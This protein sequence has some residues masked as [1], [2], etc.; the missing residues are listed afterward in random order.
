MSSITAEASKRSPSMQRQ[1]LKQWRDIAFSALLTAF[2]LWM[3]YVYLTPLYQSILQSLSQPSREAN[4]PSYPSEA[5]TF[6][7]DAQK[8]N[9]YRVPVDGQVRELALL[10]PGRARSVFIDPAD[11]TRKIEWEGSYRSLDRLWL[12]APRWSNYPEAWRRINFGRALLNTVALALISTIGVILSGI[13]VA[14]G[15]ARFR[16]PGKPV[17]M[18]VL[19]MT[20]MLPREVLFVSTYLMFYKLGWIGTW[21]PMIVPPFFGSATSIFLLRQF[22]L[23]IPRDLDEAAMIDG[24]NP[25]QILWHIIVPLSRPAIIAVGIINFIFVWNDFF[26]PTL[27]LAGK[28]ELMPLA[29]IVRSFSSSYGGTDPQLISAAAMVA[30]L[31]PIALFLLAQRPFVRAVMM[32]GLDK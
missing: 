1:S 3:A 23:N 21:L 18:T 12:L 15:F 20:M 26:N 24:A 11:P 2:V 13:L 5:R 22:F 17:L 10:E 27:Y 7:Y 29:V 9:M 28:T 14:Y 19:T 32:P 31:F 16:V 4:Q 30:S 8:L 6:E 25:L